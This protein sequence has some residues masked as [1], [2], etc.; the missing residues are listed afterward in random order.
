MAEPTTPTRDP[1]LDAACADAAPLAR[2]HL[3]D[4]VG[5]DVVG[6]HL[7]IRRE[8]ERLATHVF[9][10]TQPGYRGWTW[11]V[12]VARASR[13]RTVTVCEV[14]LLPGDEAIV[15]PSWTPYKERVRPGDLGPGDLLPPEADDARLVPGFTAG[16][17]ATEPLVDPSTVRSVADEVGMGRAWVLSLEGRDLAAERWHEGE[18]GPDVPLAQQAPGKCSDCGFTVRLAGPLGLEF[19]VCAN[20]MANDD[21]RVVALDHGCGAHSDAKLSRSS[22]PVPLPPPVIDTIAVDTLE[23]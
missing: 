16:D 15:A 22:G 2:Q 12:T 18:Q 17:P 19:G 4:T 7:A 14:V 8:G 23:V 5:E 6:D 10:S 21:G 11:S 20:G 9:A 1:R 13:Q 3:V